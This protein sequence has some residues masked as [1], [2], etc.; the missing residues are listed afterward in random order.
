MQSPPRLLDLVRRTLRTE[1][2]SRRT[3]QT[4][5][6]WIV[7]FVHFSGLR[8]PNEL[9]APEVARFLSHLANEG[10]VAASTQNQALSA[11]L[12]LYGKVL[13]QKLPWLDGLV[14]AQRPPRLPT[15]LSR[16]EVRAVLQHLTPPTWLVGSLLY[17]SGLRLLE[18]LQLRVK[19]LDFARA[20]LTVREGKGDR[21]RQT[22]LPQP[23]HEPLQRHLQFVHRQHEAD[24]RRG[25]GHV[26][27]PHALA[28]KYPNADRS[29]PWQWVFPAT[30]T[31]T[32]PETGHVRR[33]HLHETVVQR[34]MHLAVRLARLSKPAT[35]HTLR[36]SFAT[37]LLEDGYDIRTIQKL[38]GHRDV[39]TTMIYTHVLGRGPQGVRSPLEGL[40]EAERRDARAAPSTPRADAAFGPT[41]HAPL[42]PDSD[43][44]QQDR[45]VRPRNPEMD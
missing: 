19:D 3:E 38:L 22:L 16:A 35:P 44:T 13:D 20:T 5:V 17:G 24:L 9:G 18:C 14:R 10:K 23:L 8:H 45:L 15:V 36:H 11:L 34:D 32:H 21:D 31:Y 28:R 42:P 2:Y 40:V 37:H 27:L 30:R 4:Y 12:F 39:R 7:R 6:D 25:A 26:E 29:W 41:A 33:H 1:H 43:A